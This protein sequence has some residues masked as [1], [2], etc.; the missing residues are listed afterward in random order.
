MDRAHA[1]SG[2]SAG[3]ARAS[4]TLQRGGAR[5]KLLVFL[6]LTAAVVALLPFLVAKTP[7]CNSL[8][9]A[10]LP[11]NQVRIFIGDASLSW[12]SGPVLSQ[13]EVRD[14]A[15]DLLLAAERI[16]FDRAAGSLLLNRRDLGVIE[17]VRPTVHFTIRP[18]GTNWEDIADQLLKEIAAK[19]PES[20]S[21]SASPR[22][23]FAVRVVEGTVLA[24]DLARSRKWRVE[25]VVL[26]YDARVTDGGIGHGKLAAQIVDVVAPGT[27]APP[28]GRVVISLEL[29]DAGRQQLNW[30]AEN[31]TLALAEPWLRRTVVA[32]ELNGVLSSQGTTT[33]TAVAIGLPADF[34]T[35][36]SLSVDRLEASAPILN[37]DRLRLLR[38]EVPWRLVT[39]HAGLRIED[40]QLRSEIGNLAVRGT[41]DTAAFS[42]SPTFVGGLTNSAA[43]HDSELR[44]SIDLARLAAMLPRG[45]RIRADTTIAS[46]TVD[47]AGRCQPA[48]AGTGQLIT[49]SWTTS[50]LAATNAGRPVRWE[51]PVSTNVTLYRDNGATRLDALRCNSDFL[52]IAANGTPQQFSATASFD[53]NRLTQQL[54][55]FVDLSNVQLH[56]HRRGESLLDASR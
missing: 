9:S 15:G 17:I 6:A 47:I 10:V 16:S 20:E 44:G 33:W 14:A 38:V 41:L 12:F 54:G 50:Q 46:G 31:V 18:D 30:Q 32:S 56:G 40:L 11:G 4:R 26:Q 5:R 25:H 3:P 52:Q 27:M 55:Q 36:G 2:S 39:Q 37:G 34:A 35:S 21:T 28:S 48:A 43:R 24:E 53:L 42:R 51:E 19:E 22:A 23:A 7:L 1:I 49:A 8:I 29:D 45:M 13:V